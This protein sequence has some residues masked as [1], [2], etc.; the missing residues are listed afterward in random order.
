MIIVN[1]IETANAASTSVTLR[2]RVSSADE[3]LVICIN[4][5]NGATPFVTFNLSKITVA[6]TE[7][8]GAVCSA[9]IYVYT[10][11]PV[12][13]YTVIATDG[14]STNMT[15]TVM[16]LLG[17]SKRSPNFVSA[18]STATAANPSLNIQTASANSLIIDT[19]YNQVSGTTPVPDVGQ[20]Q[21]TN[22]ID[23]SSNDAVVSYKYASPGV[24]TM[25]WTIGATQYAYAAIALAP[26]D[27]PSIWYPN[28]ELRNQTDSVESFKNSARTP[29]PNVAGY[30]PS[31]FYQNSFLHT[32]GRIPSPNTTPIVFTPSMASLQDPFHA[33]TLEPNRWTLFT[34]GG[35][36]YTTSP[37]GAGTV[38]PAS[39]TSSTDGDIS[40][41]NVYDLTG[42]YAFVRI[43]SPIS[44]NASSSD[45]TFALRINGSNS[46]QFQ[47]EGGLIYAQQIVGGS[48]TNL[49]N[50][51]YTNFKFAWLRIR[52]QSGTIFWETSQDSPSGPSG[53][54]T[55][56]STPNPIVVTSLTVLLAG[57]SFGVD[58]SPGTFLYDNFNTLPVGLFDEFEFQPNPYT[59]YTS[60]FWYTVGRVI[61]QP[62]GVT[63]V[64]ET[65]LE[66]S[67]VV[68]DKITQQA[69][70]SATSITSDHLV[71]SQ[72]AVMLIFASQMGVAQALNS[73]TL[74]GVA[75]NALG[76]PS[77]STLTAGAYFVVNPNVGINTISATATLPTALE[78]IVM[79][80]LGVDKKTTNPITV[81][82]NG[83]S[84]SPSSA[85]QVTSS[86]SLIVDFVG[87]LGTSIT[88]DASQTVYFDQPQAASQAAGS[89]KLSTVGTQ[90]MNWTTLTAAWVQLVVALEPANALSIWFPAID[91]RNL[92]DVIN[93]NNLDD[94]VNPVGNFYATYGTHPSTYYLNS[95]LHTVGRMPFAKIVAVPSTGSTLLTMG[96]G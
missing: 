96:V 29:V 95:F 63:L 65:E 58:T 85:I 28:I 90:T 82:S 2:G 37:T 80:F 36:T 43:V 46:L 51:P 84:G 73:V 24:Q 60:D 19:Y 15:I 44:L 5:D 18:V 8:A 55:F 22:F 31:T 81:A 66:T 4:N 3:V 7:L 17:V 93:I 33:T 54:S 53:W 77:V 70:T 74:N 41:V 9:S 86:N 21:V 59:F 11:P 87:S 83:V 49:R 48:Q 39:T 76:N 23:S 32:V 64:A 75:L 67:Q 34:A 6:V 27:A 78:L 25:S 89:I 30:F 47:I 50:A 91:V 40:S 62:Q 1:N 68:V 12:G 71:T 94:S 88:E 26:D 35:A 16:S 38:Y 72:D 92:S 69:L 52:E 61:S 13:S 57:T 20:T 42:S 14:A 10:S 79:T 45:T 56:Y